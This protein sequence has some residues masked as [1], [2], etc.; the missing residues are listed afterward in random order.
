M[1]QL[2]R[3]NEQQLDVWSLCCEMAIVGKLRPW[4]ERCN[5]LPSVVLLSLLPPWRVQREHYLQKVPG[6]IWATQPLTQA[7]KRTGYFV[8][9]SHTSARRVFLLVGWFG[10]L[11]FCQ[12]DTHRCH[13]GRRNFN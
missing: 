2:A 9:N 12:L 6:S 10:I 5:T 3:R 13:M 7:P 1:R 4:T 8:V 11:L